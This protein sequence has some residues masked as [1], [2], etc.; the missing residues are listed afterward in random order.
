MQGLLLLNNLAPVQPHAH[1]TAQGSERFFSCTRPAVT[2]Q[3]TSGQTVTVR[4]V[5]L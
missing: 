4:T 3:M 1:A 5:T 2:L